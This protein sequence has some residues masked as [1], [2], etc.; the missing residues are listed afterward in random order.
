MSARRIVRSSLAPLFGLWIVG[1]AGG[2]GLRMEL[3]E[4]AVIP[5]HVF[6][7]VFVRGEGG[8][9][10]EEVALAIAAEL[11]GRDIDAIEIGPAVSATTYLTSDD[12]SA[13]LIDVTVVRSQSI[14]PRRYVESTAMCAPACSS[15]PVERIHDVTVLHGRVE[16]VMRD[17]RTEEE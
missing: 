3:F 11:R 2:L 14:E 8:I 10:A 17:A 15:M 5:A 16:L 4:P 9:D 7:R 13:L 6:P 12:R 1:C